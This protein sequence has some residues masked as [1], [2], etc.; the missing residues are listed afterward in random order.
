MIGFG[1]LASRL[2][3][4]DAMKKIVNDYSSDNLTD[5]E[6]K[7]LD[8]LNN[9][10]PTSKK[11]SSKKCPECNEYFNILHINNAEIDCCKKCE[12]LWFDP[13][14]L[15][16]VM[17]TADDITKDFLHAGKSKYECPICQT[18]MRKRSFLF[19]ERLVVDICPEGHG[20][21]FEKGELEQ[22]FKI[23]K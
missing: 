13:N 11:S 15:Q 16:I 14:E 18:I 5:R 6:K 10:L 22:I 7:I 4:D 2:L 9:Q 1:L 21:Y 17:K 3:I 8:T 23:K 12:G 20:V 19:P